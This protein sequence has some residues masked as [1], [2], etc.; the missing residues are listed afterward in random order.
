MYRVQQLMFASL[1]CFRRRL[2]SLP[3]AHPTRLLMS[4]IV[5]KDFRLLASGGL[6]PTHAV[7][8]P[9][10]TV[11]HRLYVFEQQ[12]VLP[13]IDKPAFRPLRVD[14]DARSASSVLHAVWCRD[15]NNDS[16]VYGLTHKSVSD[17][18]DHALADYIRYDSS[19]RAQARA[20]IRMNRMNLNEHMH[21]YMP[22]QYPNDSC[23]YHW[24][25]PESP[26]HTLTECDVYDRE[27]ASLRASLSSRF[28][29]RDADD[30]QSLFALLCGDHR[31]LS[32][33]SSSFSASRA[34]DLADF[35]CLTGDFV[36]HVQ[37]VRP[38]APIPVVLCPY[39]L[40]VAPSSSA[41]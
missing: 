4:D 12:W 28:G 33:S 19:A 41:G 9:R 5:A 26:M 11:V 37:A 36:A 38:F 2:Q 15:W 29:F 18:N 14:I 32:P 31:P 6:V 27:R 8:A 17:P 13:F 16:D 10:Q 7:S 20:R 40:H 1:L 22:R 35:F 3:P 24:L 21:K 23:P 30:S 34:D 25:T 39:V